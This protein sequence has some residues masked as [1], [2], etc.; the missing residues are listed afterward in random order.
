MKKKLVIESAEQEYESLSKKLKPD[1]NYLT[2][3]PYS[4][5]YLKLL[6]TRRKLPAF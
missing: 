5:N 1:L 3:K 4:E 2:G 6:E